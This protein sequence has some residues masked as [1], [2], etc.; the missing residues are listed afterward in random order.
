MGSRPTQTQARSHLQKLNG[1]HTDCT[2]L[3]NGR[4]QTRRLPR[5]ANL[6][7]QSDDRVPY[8]QMLSFQ[9]GITSENLH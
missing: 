5:P 1:A 3:I 7:R 9:C 2:L 6:S 8:T 4:K